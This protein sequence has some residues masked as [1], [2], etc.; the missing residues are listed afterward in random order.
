MSCSSSP[1]GRG[2]VTSSAASRAASSNCIHTTFTAVAG[3][4]AV[5][6]RG[7]PTYQGQVL[8]R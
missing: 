7:T 3:P 2:L 5:I 4:E 6:G 1:S 8:C